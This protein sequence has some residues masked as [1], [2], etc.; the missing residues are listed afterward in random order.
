MRPVKFDQ[1]NQV[2]GKPV[3]STDDQCS[4][5]YVHTGE[6]DNQGD[7]WPSIISMWEPTPEER[8]A[9]ANGANIYKRECT[10]SLPPSSL[11]VASP[12]GEKVELKETILSA[13]PNS[14]WSEA[15]EKLIKQLPPAAF[16]SVPAAFYVPQ[17]AG[18]MEVHNHMGYRIGVH[19]D[20]EQIHFCIDY[21]N[22]PD[23]DVKVIAE[24]LHIG[25]TV[26]QRV[27]AMDRVIDRL[28]KN[29]FLHPL[30]DQFINGHTA[31]SG[32]L[33]EKKYIIE[34]RGHVIGVSETHG[35]IEF[36]IDYKYSLL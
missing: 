4:P 36:S 31:G 24:V 11:F 7:R 2:Y 32:S 20:G 13:R 34:H 27:Q 10:T 3:G 15:I 19:K 26:Q 17:P 33:Y 1:H 8:Q 12:F 28:P 29:A 5:L 6:F 21:Y 30:P 9:I 35:Q 14:A 23:N 25:S 18:A 22:E 16:T